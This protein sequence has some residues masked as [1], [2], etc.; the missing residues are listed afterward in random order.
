MK[1]LNRWGWIGVMLIAAAG[2]VHAATEAQFS[3]APYA[4]VLK[5]YVNDKGLVN[6]EALKANR[7]ELDRF[8]RE[9]ADL[10]P[11]VYQKWTDKEKIAFWIN[12]Y[13]AL[14]LEVVIDH[15]P[16]KAG[17]LAS[18]VYPSNSIRQV[19]GVWG[20]ITFSLMGR[21]T[22]LDDIE[23]RLRKEFQEP[24][25]HLALVYASMG[26]PKLRREPYTA[27]KLD[28]QFADQA[29]NFVAD[30]QKFRINRGR[31][32]V[33][34][35]P[36]F[37]WFGED[38]VAKY[39]TSMEYVG[40]DAAERAVLNYLSRYLPEQKRSFLENSDYEIKYLPYDWALNAQPRR[41]Q[42]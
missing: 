10:D 24:R 31:G 17:F 18:L 30:R 1:W 19:P 42:P 41:K 13:N 39:S 21:P 11:S 23:G 29:R 32:R 36:I 8:T 7:A 20:Q 3:Y 14:T 34:L 40:H 2:L 22:T 16:I 15:Y 9:L 38:F 12:A 26:S 25:I 27:A 33:M 6:Y 5:T 28:E 4:R 37:K 35:S